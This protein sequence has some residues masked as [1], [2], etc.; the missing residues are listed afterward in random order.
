MKARPSIT[1][2]RPLGAAAV[3]AVVGALLVPTTAGG[4]VSHPV[5]LG[6]TK[7]TPSGNICSAGVRCTY[8]PVSSTRLRV[9]F[10]GTVTRF[11]VN[12]GSA[13]G[14]VWLRVLRSAGGGKF[15]GIS[16]SPPKMLNVGLN[17]F[18]V[19]L[20]VKKGDL[21]GLD[22]ATS[23]LMFDTSSATALTAY[24]MPALK[25]GHMA[26][27]TAAQAGYRLLLSATVRRS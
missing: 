15:T 8:L 4:A 14:I 24:Y 23:A 26:A 17:S 7:G 12:A 5:T 25:N 19:S 9:P 22:N 1:S 20:R 11:R 27:P 2:Q 6:S 16:T 18:A 3:A 10:N 13:G 21:I